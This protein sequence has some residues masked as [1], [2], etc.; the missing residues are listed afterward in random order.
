MA[1]AAP[2]E[3]AAERYLNTPVAASA[4]ALSAARG[5]EEDT[6]VVDLVQRA[7]LFYAKADVSFTA[8]F[9]PEVRIPQGQVT[10]RQIAALYPYDNELLAIEGT[11]RMVKDALEN[12]ARYFSGNGFPGFNY[13]MASGVSYEIDRSRPEGDR[14]R[15]LQW[16]GRPLA[17][18]QKLRIAVNSY[19]AGGSGGYVMFRRAKA[20]WRSGEDIREL[21]I[22]YCTE[23]KTIPV[24]P[25]GNWRIV[26]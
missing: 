21:V 18:E 8:L 9:D 20:L 16:R 10:V 2:Y 4:R 22:R 23:R 17:P 26:K 24:E 5:R 11:G 14:I 13:D 6:A 7:Q 15:D 3:A 19:R 12:A 1:M 25:V